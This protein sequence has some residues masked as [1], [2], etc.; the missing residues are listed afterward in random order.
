MLTLTSPITSN[1]SAT[2]FSPATDLIPDSSIKSIT[3]SY[4]G[5]GTTIFD[6]VSGQA[7]TSQYFKR[8]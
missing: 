7:V 5:A 1:L 8:S 4:L 2:L 3:D 6:I